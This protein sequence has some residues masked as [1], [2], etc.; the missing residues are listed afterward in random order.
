MWEKVTKGEIVS[1]YE[2]SRPTTAG[3]I[4]I[5]ECI[6]ENPKEIKSFA[7]WNA[8]SKDQATKFFPNFSASALLQMC[9]CLIM[10]CQ[11]TQRS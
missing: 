4:A 6:S 1:M 2:I 7:G 5:L 11:C 3:I 8:I 10:A 9:Y